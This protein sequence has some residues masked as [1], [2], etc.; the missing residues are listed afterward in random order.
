M[1]A[2]AR[3]RAMTVLGYSHAWFEAGLLSE[4]G[5][6]EQI[7]EW[8]RPAADHHPEHYRFSTWRTSL[9]TLVDLPLDLLELLLAL[10]LREAAMGASSF[11][12]G[13]A[14][15]VAKHPALGVEGLARLRRH[16]VDADS[17][18]RALDAVQQRLGVDR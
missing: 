4:E 10:D 5:L 15:D 18:A 3:E 13:I 1:N 14:Y 7:D 17:F 2:A 6:R 9:A 12:H 16:P 8:D 11:G